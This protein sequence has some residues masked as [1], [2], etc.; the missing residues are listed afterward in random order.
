MANM[1]DVYKTMKRAE[2]SR[3]MMILAS[4]QADAKRYNLHERHLAQQKNE[5]NLQGRSTDEAVACGF[6]FHNFKT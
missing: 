5:P 6:F 2:P 4:L 3:K 1:D